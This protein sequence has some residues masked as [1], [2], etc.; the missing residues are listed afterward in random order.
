LGSPP[1]CDGASL[2]SQSAG[3][4]RPRLTSF[5]HA[6]TRG[7]IAAPDDLHP[8][9]GLGGGASAVR[10]SPESNAA[11]GLG[12]IWNGDG[13]SRAPAGRA[14]G[15]VT[16]TTLCRLAERLS[17]MERATLQGGRRIANRLLGSPLRGPRVRIPSPPSAVNR[18][19]V[20]KKAALPLAEG[21]GNVVFGRVDPYQ[22][23][24]TE[25]LSSYYR[26][27]WFP[28]GR[29]S[30]RGYDPNRCSAVLTGNGDLDRCNHALQ[31]MA[32]CRISCASQRHA[33]QQ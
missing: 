9:A 26:R 16:D 21:L 18:G 6:A 5:R 30:L 33:G 27:R 3:P 4:A 23:A 1:L 20:G 8:A 29:G 17:A 31:P 15:A 25:T 28:A 7:G 32:L 14:G 2:V 22:F 11:G 19:A 12:K 13:G 10:G 24:A